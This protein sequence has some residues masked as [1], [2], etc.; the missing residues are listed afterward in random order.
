VNTEKTP[1]RATKILIMGLPGSGKTTLAKKLYAFLSKWHFN[2]QID[3]FNADE[4]R[5]Q[6]DDWDFSDEGRLRQGARMAQLASDSQADFVICD[7]VAPFAQ[8][9]EQFQADCII[10]MDTISAGR[11]AD[12]NA[13][14]I[15]P[16]TYDFRVTEKDADAW[17][18]LIGAELTKKLLPS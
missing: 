9:R 16:Q 14:F 10:W 1:K 13:A 6:F 18:V 15:A 4:V 5:K 8:M 7:F 12:T 2:I 17:S 3:W 11:F